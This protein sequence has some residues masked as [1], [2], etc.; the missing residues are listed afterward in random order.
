MQRALYRG[1]TY[2]EANYPTDYCINARDA[3]WVWTTENYRL[4]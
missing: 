1:G 2:R 4:L 3:W